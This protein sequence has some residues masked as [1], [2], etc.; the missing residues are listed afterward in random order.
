MAVEP[1]EAAANSLVPA[2][3]EARVTDWAVV[4]GLF[5]ASCSWTVIGPRVAVADA[6]P[7]TAVDVK[8]YLDG[9]PAVTVSTWVPLVVNPE[10]VMVGVPARVS[11]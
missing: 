10:A 6:A 9:E 5:R 1:P 8:A 2:E 11:P 4:V 3:L 7:D